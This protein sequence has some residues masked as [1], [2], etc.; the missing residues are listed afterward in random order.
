MVGA[1]GAVDAGGAAEFGDDDDG[2]VFPARAQTLLKF[3]QR[4]VE[5]AEQLR[6]PPRRAALIGMGVPAVEGE[7]RDARAVIGRHQARRARR[8]R[9]HGGGVAA[10]AP[11][12]GVRAH[13][14]PLRHLVRVDA[15]SQGA[16]ERWIAVAV[17][18]HDAHREIIGGDRHELRRPAEHGGRAAQDQRRR[19]ADGK[20]LLR[21]DFLA[22]G[23]SR[24]RAVEPAGLHLARTLKAAFEHVLPVKMRAL[25]VAGRRRM[26]H[27]GMAGFVEPREDR[28]GGVDREETVERQRRVLA[29][30]RQRDFA[31]EGGIIGIADRRD[32]RQT[33]HRAAQD[34]GD[35]S[36]V[37]PVGGAGE[38]R[39]MRPGEER[40]AGQQ[41]RAAGGRHRFAK[42]CHDL[43]PLKF[44]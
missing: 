14:L 11:F 38:F 17:K 35:Q 18:V 16:G 1:G 44:G 43:S 30:E 39:Q 8:R 4:A 15:I 3:L 5:P 27:C 9:A 29:G 28:H 33:V 23:Q 22:L 7:S 12:G 26:H 25:A 13:A 36:G 6:Q 31:V 41:Q 2:R 24:Q 20:R 40:A 21:R 19:G 42:E 32:R 10:A 34:D 37:A